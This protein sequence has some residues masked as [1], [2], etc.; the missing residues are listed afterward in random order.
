M[1]NITCPNC[2]KHT[3]K[4][5]G[6]K[7]FYLSVEDGTLIATCMLCRFKLPFIPSQEA[8]VF[9]LDEIRGLGS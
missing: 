6:C 4:E 9:G 3:Y 2:R 7:G 5:F 1:V 8:D